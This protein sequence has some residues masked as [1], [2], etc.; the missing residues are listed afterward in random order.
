M[1]VLLTGANGS[2][3]T[4]I[5]DHLGD[6]TA[7]EWTYLDVEDNPDEETVVADL[8]DYASVHEAFEGQDAVIHLAAEAGSRPRPVILKN[9][10]VATWN[11][12]EAACQAG[13]ETFVFASTNHVMD[14]YY[15]D[16]APEIYS[17]ESDLLLDHTDPVRPGSNYSVSK[18]FGEALGR[19]YV[20]Y[21][22]AP[23]RFYAIRIASHRT[24]DHPYA[25]AENG[26]AAGRFERGSDAYEDAVAQLKAKW[27]SRRDCAHMFER[28][29]QADDEGFGVFYGVSDN[30][31]RWFGIEHARERIGYD[32]RDNAADWDTPPENPR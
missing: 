13:V 10:V 3:G 4:T 28:C 16:H 30:D 27:F 31:R 7:Y 15:D 20:E 22:G 6:S 17:L 29:L 32:P 19:Y 9:N 12:L 18:V 21:R 23:E 24:E 26:V 11:A 14:G 2:I 8:S 1:R 25:D 5:R